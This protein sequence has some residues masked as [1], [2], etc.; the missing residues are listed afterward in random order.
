MNYIIW[1]DVSRNTLDIYI[2]GNSHHTIENNITHIYNFFNSFDCKKYTILFEATWIYSNNLIKVCNDL[3][4]D[5]FIITPTLSYNLSTSLFGRN[6]NDKL[7]AKKISKIGNLLF[8]SFWQL[9]PTLS[10]PIHNSILKLKAIHR[11]ILSIK[12]QIKVS[13]NYLEVET[14]DPFADRNVINY[15]KSDIKEK[16]KKLKELYEKI[17][18]IIDKMWYTNHLRNLQTIP[19]I[20]E[21][22]AIEL[23]ILFLELKSKWFTKKD[24][25]KVKAFMWIEPNEKKS[26]KSI[27][28]VK[29]SKKWRWYLRKMLF[30]NALIWFK[31][32]KEEKTREKYKNTNIWKFFVRMRDKFGS[33]WWKRWYSVTAAMMNKLVQVAW[34]IFRNNKPFNYYV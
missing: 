24:W 32:F 1:I 14:K 25:K 15:Y 5:Y 3:Q 26:W 31:I 11:A 33:E 28:N 27:N 17:L 20:W 4:L 9:P 21:N 30:M 2:D 12:K 10:K 6:S 18:K 23:I 13:K 7:D 8:T 29:I 16:E 22:T 19:S 34:W